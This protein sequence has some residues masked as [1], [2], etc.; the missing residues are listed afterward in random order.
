MLFNAFKP[1]ANYVFDYKPRYYNPRKERLEELKK[2]YEK[3]EGEAT[4]NSSNEEIKVTLTKNNLKDDWKRHKGM[5]VDRRSN[6]RLAIIITILVAI[7]AYL[8]GF[9]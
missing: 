4:E 6:R 8:L 7:V 1:R 5:A 9:I 3:K 2:K